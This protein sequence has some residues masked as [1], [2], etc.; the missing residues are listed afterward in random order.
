MKG[1]PIDASLTRAVRTVTDLIMGKFIVVLDSNLKGFGFGSLS[2]CYRLDSLR[3]WLTFTC[4]G[5][6]GQE[7]ESSF[8]FSLLSSFD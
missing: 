7:G 5:V 3:W 2:C 4:I 1:H 6:E 8:A